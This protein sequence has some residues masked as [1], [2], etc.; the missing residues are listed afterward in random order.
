MA[1]PIPALCGTEMIGGKGRSVLSR[2]G[3]LILAPIT[4]GQ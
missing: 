1:M 2:P 3:P 4:P